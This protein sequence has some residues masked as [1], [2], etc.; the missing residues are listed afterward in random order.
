MIYINQKSI[1]IKTF[2]NVKTH[3]RVCLAV[4]L[5]S[6]NMVR[7]PSSVAQPKSLIYLGPAPVVWGASNALRDMGR[8]PSVRASKRKSP[9]SN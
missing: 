9:K 7:G 3:F 4:S 1:N 8:D 5:V 6:H 2:K